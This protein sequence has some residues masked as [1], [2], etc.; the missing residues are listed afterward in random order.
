MSY[1]YITVLFIH[2]NIA[3]QNGSRIFN[4]IVKSI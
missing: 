2:E 1:Q 3:R 4:V